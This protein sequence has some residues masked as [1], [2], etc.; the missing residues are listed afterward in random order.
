MGRTE[1][2]HSARKRS[3]EREKII[4]LSQTKLKHSHKEDS[5]SLPTADMKDSGPS[6][7][8]KYP[9]SVYAVG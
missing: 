8:S 4:T 9:L 7:K 5:S 1:Q 6:T 3:D 2:K